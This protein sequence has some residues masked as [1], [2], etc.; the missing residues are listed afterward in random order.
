[1]SKGK[2]FKSKALAAV[3]AASMVTT[4]FPVTAFAVTGDQVAKDGTYTATKHVVNNPEDENPWD[5]YD[6]TVS[7][8]VADGKFSAIEVTPGSD[9]D[10]END[11]YYNKAVNKSKGIQTLL[12]GQAASAA[13]IEGW[14]TVSNAT[15]TS[16]AV[17]EAALEA[18]A[19]AEEA[20]TAEQPSQPV[21]EG[22]VYGTVNLP[23]ADF[24]YGEINNVKQDATLNLEA[25]DPAADFR[26]AYDVMASATKSGKS[27]GFATTY[28]EETAAGGVNIIGIKDVN[29]AVPTA[30][31]NAAKEAIEQ[32]KT[33]N[34]KLLDIVGSMTVTDSQPAEYKILNGDGTLTAM[35]T[36]TVVDSNAT[37]TISTSTPW[38]NYLVTVESDLMPS[39]REEL[40]GVVFVT[41]DGARY[42]L[43]HEENIWINADE[44]AFAV[45]DGFKEPKAGNIMDNKRYVGIEG[46]TITQ[47]IYLIKDKADLVVNTNLVVQ[48]LLK[49]GQG[50]AASDAVF[51]DGVKVPVTLNVPAGSNYALAS[52]TFGG[53]ALEEGTDYTY[54]NNTLTVNATDN[55]GIGAYTLLYTSE[56]YEQFSITVNLTS[57][58]AEGA[59][60][61]VNNE[62][63]LPEGVDA[64]NYLNNVKE[65]YV[66]DAKIGGSGLG[67]VFNA[68]GK[69]NVDAA[70]TGR[71]SATLFPEN[72]TYNL[73]IVSAGY[74]TVT[75]TVNVVKGDYV[76]GTVNLP[77]ADFYYGEINNVE[78]NATINLEA[79]DPAAD[80]RV[81]YDVMSSATNSGKVT[82]FATTYFET[83]EDGGVSI[84]GIKDVNV[85]IPRALY[86]EAKKLASGREPAACNN[87]LLNIVKSFT[88][89]GYEPDEYKIL[90]GD[91][92]LTAMKTATEVDEAAKATISTDTVWGNYLVEV[93]SEKLPSAREEVMGVIFETSDGAKYGLEHEENIWVRA[94][95]MAFA[96]EDNFVE[97]HGSTMDNKRFLDIQGKTITKITYLVKDKADLVV[98]TNLYVQT[99]LTE[100]QGGAASDAVFADGVKVPVTLNVPAGSNY[101]LASVTYDG[102]TLTEGT[103]YTF[104]N[105]VLTVKDT[106]NTDIGAYTLLFTS[107]KY[108][109][110]KVSFNL[111]STLADGSIKIAN[112]KLV[113]PA[114]TDIAR[115]LKNVTALKVNGKSISGSGL[116]SIFNADGTLNPDAETTGR[117]K[118]VIFPEDGTY[119]LEITSAGFPFVK[120]TVT[121]GAEAV[122]EL[123]ILK[124]LN[125]CPASY[126]LSLSKEGTNYTKIRTSWDEIEGATFKYQW[127]STNSSIVKASTKGDTIITKGVKKGS[128]TCICLATVT[129][130]DG[131]TATTAHAMTIKVV[132]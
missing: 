68:N 36:E 92:T 49:D 97:P 87:Q 95:E 33:C 121:K 125:K 62:L 17:K 14:D 123:P 89:T 127:Y 60:K 30:L 52:V 13:T 32:G 124:L 112:N 88:T 93:E 43:E 109:Q 111:T 29:I 81:A 16:T 1:M 115:Y 42:G 104:A 25:A 65:L 40:Y 80:F 38:G 117:G 18:I 114:G 5:E 77:Y 90:N 120:G 101:I 3:L 47:V 41:S 122:T 6:V 132:K 119:E 63:V 19:Q 113:V 8:T 69:L 2:D 96:V 10:S 39:A 94:G 24:Y 129:L 76:Y 84:I 59:I 98:N 73:K 100:G 83:R 45:E 64:A 128:A 35:K 44:L 67:S 15:R 54:A 9:Y 23:Y 103:D 22:Y 46:K 74:P 4:V 118:T 107:E 116:G 70:T 105:N 130:P 57:T 12:V 55:T 79:A 106:E 126:K 66:N 51:A 31:Y 48:T 37:A 26:V 61:I 56:K 91:G 110:F 102:K 99:L 7:L 71:G 50:A 58:V 75:G 34:N 78:Q 72:G 108:A 20:A 21:E 131:T 28:Y 85:A 86:D 27:T 82:G 53:K 11:I